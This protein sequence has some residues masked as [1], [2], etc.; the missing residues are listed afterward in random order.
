M[1]AKLRLGTRKLP[2]P[3]LVYNIDQSINKS[4][5]ITHSCDLFVTKGNKKVQQA[6]YVTNLG[7]NEAI[8]GYPWLQEFNPDIDWMVA[9]VLEPPTMIETIT[10]GRN[11]LQIQAA[12][13]IPQPKEGDELHYQIIKIEMESIG[14]VTMATEMAIQARDPSKESMEEIIPLQYQW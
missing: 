12:Q 1:V 10:K 5:T 14:K 2:K 4:G 8:L 11:N 9:K 13:I 6:F 7:K 3:R